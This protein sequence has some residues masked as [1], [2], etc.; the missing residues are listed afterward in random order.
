VYE[1]PNCFLAISAKECGLVPTELGVFYLAANAAWNLFR[2][3]GTAAAFYETEKTR[4]SGKGRSYA[5]LEVRDG[6]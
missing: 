6:Y 3:Y 2:R 4:M 1:F 5:Y